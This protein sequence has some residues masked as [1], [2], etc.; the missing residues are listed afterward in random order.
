MTTE[1]IASRLIGL[2]KEHKFIEAQKELYAM[3]VLSIETDGGETRGVEQMHAKEQRFL[4]SLEKIHSI[5]F[6]EPLVA[7]SYFSARLVMEVD[8][9][10]VG[11]R[12]MEEICLYKV[13]HDKIVFEQFFRG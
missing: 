6:S 8:I 10:G 9:K 2:C 12:V 5:S 11:Y 3:D 1:E 7:G 4:D 13:Q